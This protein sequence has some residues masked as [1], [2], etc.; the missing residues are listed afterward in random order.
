MPQGLLQD[1]TYITVMGACVIV[2]I[3]AL[4]RKKDGATLCPVNQ[5]G[6]KAMMERLLAGQ[7]DQTRVLVD[8]ASDIKILK[9]RSHQ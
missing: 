5:N 7:A 8:M 2:A 4:A 9:D 3:K 6:F 1:G